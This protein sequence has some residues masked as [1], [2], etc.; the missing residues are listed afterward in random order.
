M[1]MTIRNAELVVV[2]VIW[3]IARVASREIYFLLLLV[4]VVVVVVRLKD[5]GRDE[6]C[7]LG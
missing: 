1:M 3:L 7:G 5:V 4:L 6:L 2:A